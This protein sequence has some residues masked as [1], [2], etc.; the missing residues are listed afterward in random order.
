ML[1]HRILVENDILCIFSNNF[2]I[3]TFGDCIYICNKLSSI[4]PY[5]GTFLQLSTDFCD[6]LVD[7][8]HETI[9]SQ[10]VDDATGNTIATIQCVH[11]YELDDGSHTQ[12]A[13]CTPDVNG[14]TW[15]F[16]KT[17]QGMPESVDV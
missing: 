12:T 13:V 8:S 7:G 1:S 14:G 17:C 2:F 4:S 6:N 5:K 3:I 11:C 16:I 9:I 15:S 10:Y